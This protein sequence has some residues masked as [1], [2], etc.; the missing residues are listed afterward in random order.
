MFIQKILQSLNFTCKIIDTYVQKFF[1]KLKKELGRKTWRR[2]SIGRKI[3]IQCGYESK[4]IH[5]EFWTLLWFGKSNFWRQKCSELMF[6]FIFEIVNLNL[7]NAHPSQNTEIF[8]KNSVSQNEQNSPVLKYLLTV[9]FPT[10]TTCFPFNLYNSIVP[11]VNYCFINI[12]T[13]FIFWIFRKFFDGVK[14][15]RTL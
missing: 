9:C 14:S 8:T 13:K 5:T 4:K 15:N 1:K 3:F 2:K 12:F 10:S 11:V 7:H 6:F